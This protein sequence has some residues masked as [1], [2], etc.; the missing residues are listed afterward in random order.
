MEKVILCRTAWMKFYEGR[1]NKDIPRSG[2]KYIKKNKTGG[3]IYNFKDVK[4]KVFAYFPDIGNPN[5]KNLDIENCGEALSNVTVVFCA[6]HPT[7]S[8][9]R[10]V[11]WYKNATVFPEPQIG[12]YN[13]WVHT[14]AKYKNALL[15]QEDDRVF[16]V[17]GIFGRSSLFY[18]S[19]HPEHK[20]LLTKLKA[21]I[22]NDGVI[23]GGKNKVKGPGKNGR[24]YQP[25]LEKKLK[26]EQRAID[27]AKEYYKLRYGKANVRSVESENKGWDLEVR[28]KSVKINVEVKG[29]SGEDL[30]IELTPNEYLN[31]S[32]C[33]N[34][35]HLFVANK[36]LTK[37]PVIRVFKYQEKGKQWVANDKSTLDIRV[38]KSARIGLKY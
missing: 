23:K 4:G 28:R 8:G 1:A 17:S 12:H 34:N 5:L 18:F 16:D 11:G 6:T 3:E 21:Y 9:M 19:R 7:E 29:L 31:F 37:K 33:S 38:V 22:A 15:L 13:N 32:K 27:K 26:V 25:D 14:S 35:Y 30:M 2:A 36:V 10:V 24:A 20:K